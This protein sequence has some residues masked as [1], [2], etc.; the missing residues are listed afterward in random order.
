MEGHPEGCR[1][2]MCQGRAFMGGMHGQHRWGH[3]LIKIIL[4]I[5]I[6]WCGV[7]FGELKSMLGHGY[8]YPNEGMMGWYG[9]QSQGAYSGPT[10]MYGGVYGASAQPVTA[11][12]TR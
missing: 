4:A 3:I 8:A 6:F 11:T 1:C 12:T 2:G 7:Q 5:F 10:M 9:Q